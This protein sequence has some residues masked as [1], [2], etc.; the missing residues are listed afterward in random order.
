MRVPITLFSGL[1]VAAAL[2]GCGGA[3]SAQ[4]AH[5][6]KSVLPGTAPAEAYALV[7][8]QVKGCWF[9]PA[10][11]VLT[12]HVF[13]AEAPAGGAPGQTM[14]VIYDQTPDGKRGLKAYSVLFEPRSKGT[15]VTTQNHKLAYG[16]AQKLSSDVGYWIQGGANCDGPAPTATAPSR[17][18]FGGPR[19]VSTPRGSY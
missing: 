1:F 17:G 10:N 11:P 16:L 12:K 8:R 14:I 3:P 15:S 6:Q 4:V 5:G 13:R 18:S 2:A 9:N 19:P 7:A